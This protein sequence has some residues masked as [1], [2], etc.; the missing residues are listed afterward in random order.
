MKTKFRVG[1]LVKVRENLKSGKMYYMED[2]KTWDKFF[3]FNMGD[4]RG[5]ILEIVEVSHDK[6]IL[7]GN[8]YFWTD[9]ML[10]KYPIKIANPTKKSVEMVKSISEIDK[11]IQGYLEEIKKLEKLKTETFNQKTF[12]AS[13]CKK[14]TNIE[15]NIFDQDIKKEMFIKEYDTDI[16]FYRHKNKIEAQIT[17]NDGMFYG[18]GFAKCHED[19][20]FD[21]I[22]GLNLALNRAYLN[23][24]ARKVKHIEGRS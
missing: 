5:K 19:D 3:E 9:G 8:D 21:Y 24:Y 4:C 13:I 10:E 15:L 11:E 12:I 17:L 23:A 7:K 2:G 1:D 22:T 18:E 20:D 14:N 16:R 6:Y